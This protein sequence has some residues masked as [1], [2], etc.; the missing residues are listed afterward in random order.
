VSVLCR[1]RNAGDWARGRRLSPPPSAPPPPSG[2]APPPPGPPPPG[3]YGGGP[4]AYGSGPPAYGGGTPAP[5]QRAPQGYGGPQPPGPPGPPPGWRPPPAANGVP[6]AASRPAYG[7][8]PAQGAAPPAYGAPP[9]PAAPAAPPRPAYGAPPPPGPAYGAPPPQPPAARPAPPAGF[10]PPG[11]PPPPAAYG[12]PRPPAFQAPPQQQQAAAPPPGA[13]GAPPAPGGG[14]AAPPAALGGFAAAPPRPPPGPYAAPPPPQYGAPQQAPPPLGYGGPPPPGP[15]AFG[16]APPAAPPPFGGGAPPAFGGAPHY[17]APAAPYGGA[18]VLDAPEAINLAPAAGAPGGD[19]S[20]FPRPAGDA[21]GAA[22]AMPTHPVP[23][24]CDPRFMRLTV[25]AVPA[26]QATRARF[27]LPVGAIVHPM[28][29]PQDVPVVPL[30]AA[31]I[32]RCRRCRTYINPFVT[33]AD[34]GRRFACNVCAALNDVP[35]EYYC[36]LDAD[37][38]RLDAGERPELAGGSVEYVAPAEY[39][40]RPPMPPAYFFCV[41]VS[42]PAVR[43]GM[44]AVVAATIKKC[45]DALPGGGRARVGLLTF[46]S[47]LHFYALK[48][49]AAAPAMVVVPDVDDPFVPLPDDL[50]VNA[51]E[52]RALLD[53]ALDALPGAVAQTTTTES[54]AGA[55]LQ[56]AYMVLAPTGG[57]L[58]LFQASLPNAGAGKLRPRD[59]G[60]G[61]GTDAEH[62]QRLPDDPFWK[63]YA[64]E[65][66]RA[67]VAVDVFCCAGAPA[68]LASLGAL[69]KYTCGQLYYYPGFAAARDGGRLAAELEHN[70]RRPTGWEA[71]MRVRCSKGLRISAFHGHFFVR[72]TDLLALPQVGGGRG[73]VVG[74]GGERRAPTPCRPLSPQVDPDKA[75]AVQIAHEEGVVSGPTAYVQCAL[76]YTASCG[77]RRIRVHTLAVPVVPD[78][79]DLYRAVD[80]GATAALLAKLAVEKACGA[81][82][83]ETRAAIAHK[84]GL[85]LREYRLAASGGGR[86]APPHTALLLP[87]GLRHLPV[88]TLG[89]AKC[90]ALRGGARDVAPDE[91]A[92]VG[93]DIMAASVPALLRML[94]PAALPLHDPAGEWGRPRP[95][96]A[97]PLL[98]APAPLAAAALDPAG[99][100]LLDSGRVLILWLGRAVR[101][102][103]MAAVFGVDPSRPPPDALSLSPEPPRPGSDLS[104]RVCAVLDALRAT[105]PNA[106]PL[107]VVQAGTPSEA[108]V[109]PFFVEDRTAAGPSY[110]EFAAGLQKT[111]LAKT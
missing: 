62:K 70:I 71:V 95:G 13:Y 86:G 12:V 14:F 5:P 61:W 73:G 38:R 53:A 100:Y 1:P 108:H 11:A 42:A 50:L 78:L 39:M 56:A 24:S 36:A 48:P 83:E 77:E 93:H 54:A 40:V 44:V 51:G 63:R 33:W 20:A 90:G 9:L 46:D 55:A 26:Q 4:P 91:R 85:A 82:L 110:A 15:P 30:T 74:G 47:A 109:A 96:G 41:D 107:F 45:L 106:P 89:V 23:G 67:Q 8:P 59:P 97:P 43:S 79:A 27:Q 75:F 22:G 98:P 88:W 31:G 21:A 64:A 17:G 18:G 111:A 49:G 7:A 37:G 99:A 68:D 101:P 66:S 57:K 81:R 10:A 2:F 28:A 3:Q 35:V 60:A 104:A 34:G 52:A 72:S 58:L 65:A 69:P 16:G 87:A 19:P 102:D 25:N 76:L 94:Y 6:P 92:A 29:D 84:V 32:V 80:G 105:R 103:F